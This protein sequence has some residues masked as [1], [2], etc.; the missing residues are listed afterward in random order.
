VDGGDH[1]ADDA[2]QAENDRGHDEAAQVNGQ[3]DV[4]AWRLSPR[5]S[6]AATRDGPGNDVGDGDAS[7][8]S[9]ESNGQGFGENCRRMCVCARHG[10]FDADLAGA[11][12]DGDQHNVHQADAADAQG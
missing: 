3:V 11:L 4:P 8:A 9:G 1:A 10:F 7:Q 2:D 5:R 12:L 6:S